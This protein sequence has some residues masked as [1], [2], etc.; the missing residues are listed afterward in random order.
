MYVYINIHGTMSKH[1]HKVFASSPSDKINW[2][3]NLK[4]YVYLVRIGFGCVQVYYT[5]LWSSFP[6]HPLLVSLGSSCIISLSPTSSVQ[7][8]MPRQPSMPVQSGFLTPRCSALITPLPSCRCR[9][10]PHH[11]ISKMFLI[12]YIYAYMY[13]FFC[14]IC[15]SLLT[16]IRMLTFILL[17]P[18]EQVHGV[19]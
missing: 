8:E 16:F 17:P 9:L 13:P 10:L 11:P 1:T 3:T 18:G 14:L 12:T 5:S 15:D 6:S 2:L 19:Q 4:K 7:I